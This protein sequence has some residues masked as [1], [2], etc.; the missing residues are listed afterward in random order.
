MKARV[1]FE[2]GPV[3]T[4]EVAEQLAA[5]LN[6]KVTDLVGDKGGKLELQAWREF[7][8]DLEEIAS[9]KFPFVVKGEAQFNFVTYMF[10]EVKKLSKEVG[11]LSAKFDR[12]VTRDKSG[13]VVHI[14]NQELL[15][16]KECM[17]LNDCCTDALNDHISNGWRILAICPQ[18]NQR[19]PDYIMGRLPEEK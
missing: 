2:Y 19:R 16:I 11:G 18:P 7:E 1:S 9:F 12:A 15:S 4:M 17:V 10:D 13:I 5:R 8:G 3:V 14:P 6:V